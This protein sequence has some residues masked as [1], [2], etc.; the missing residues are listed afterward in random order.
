MRKRGR[1]FTAA[2]LLIAAATL[3]GCADRN[4]PGAQPSAS[5]SASGSA[6]PSAAPSPTPTETQAETQAPIAQDPADY[7]PVDFGQ[8]VVFTSPERDLACGIVTLTDEPNSSVWGCAIGTDKEWEFPDSDPSDFCYD[9]HVPCGYGIE[10]TGA[11]EP[12][13]RMRG[14]AAFESEY[15]ETSLA[16]PIGS[17]VGY[18]NVICTSTEA[19]ISCAHALSGHGFAISASIN[20]IW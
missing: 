11:G 14:D 3:G 16:L 19:G 17:S 12:H 15:L 7:A 20:D 6:T 1:I 2:V 4:A 10:A 18:D 9:A 8:G 13:P 5:S